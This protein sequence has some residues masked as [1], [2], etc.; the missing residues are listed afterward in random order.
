MIWSREVASSAAICFRR[1]WYSGAGL[2]IGAAILLATPPM[3]R[4]Q[5][6]AQDP[7][8]I[9]HAFTNTDAQSLIGL[10]MGTYKTIVT[11]QGNLRWSHWNL[12]N[13]PLDSPFGFTD[14]LDGELGIEVMN[15]SSMPCLLYT[16]RCV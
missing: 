16:S 10:P 11:K 2:C 1:C 9:T 15:A 3:M 14:Q 8:H 5:S 4:A 13:K 7:V 12:K 6:S